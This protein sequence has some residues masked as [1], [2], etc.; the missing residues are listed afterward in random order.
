MADDILDSADDGEPASSPRDGRTTYDGTSDGSPAGPKPKKPRKSTAASKKTL[1]EFAET[2]AEAFE[3]VFPG[4]ENMPP[5]PHRSDT[6]ALTPLCLDWVAT[7]PPK[8]R[9]AC[10]KSGRVSDDARMCYVCAQRIAS[11]GPGAE[12]CPCI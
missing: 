5:K 10:E 3:T 9:A 2:P 12:G 6:T 8:L 7:I 4:G 1:G 11:K